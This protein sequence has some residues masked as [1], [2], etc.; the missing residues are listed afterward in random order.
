MIIN[1][2]NKLKLTTM[3]RTREH[4]GTAL[5]KRVMELHN[6]GWFPVNIANIAHID[7]KTV[8]DVLKRHNVILDSNDNPV[9]K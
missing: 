1:L 4:G 7:I 3:I 5:D 6:E 8:R 9:I 2:N